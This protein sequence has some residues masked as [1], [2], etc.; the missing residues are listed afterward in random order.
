MLVL[1]STLLKTK[2]LTRGLW[3]GRRAGSPVLHGRVAPVQKRE[4]LVLTTRLDSERS[5]KQCNLYA[6]AGDYYRRMVQA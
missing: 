1:Y 4:G 2:L 5:K 3:A 6:I